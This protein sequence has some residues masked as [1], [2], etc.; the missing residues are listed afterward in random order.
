MRQTLHQLQEAVFKSAGPCEL[1]IFPV[2][3]HDKVFVIL[4][5][6]DS[7]AKLFMCHMRANPD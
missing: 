3:T 4:G 1:S 7:L 5:N 2:E 6:D